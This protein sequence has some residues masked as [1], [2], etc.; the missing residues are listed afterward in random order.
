[1]TGGG[2]EGVGGE[3]VTLR[4]GVSVVCASPGPPCACTAAEV[5]G[6]PSSRSDSDTPPLPPPFPALLP[7]A[8]PPASEQSQQIATDA[9]SAHTYAIL[10]ANLL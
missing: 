10:A 6:P 4:I 8:P 1:M 7:V 9:C 2:C 5:G 3:M